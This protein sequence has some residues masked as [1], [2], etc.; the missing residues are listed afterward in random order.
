MKNFEKQFKSWQNKPFIKQLF[1]VFPKAEVFLVGGAVRD[2]ILNR[3]TKDYDLVIRNVSKNQLEKFLSK[4]GKVNLVGK[5]FGVFKFV[6]KGWKG[7]EIDIALPRTEHSIHFSGAYKDFKI[8]S[9]A[10]L[11]IEDDLNR[12]DFTINAMAYQLISEKQQAGKPANSLIDPFNGMKDLKAKKI[13][14]VGDV[15]KR[16]KEDYSRMLRAIRF[17]CQLDFKIEAKTWVEIKKEIKKLIKKIDSGQIIPYEVI[18]KELFKAVGQNPILAI[19][20]LDESG[21]I[22]VLMPE[23]L[24]MK[25]CPQPKNFHSEGDVWKHTILALQ[26]LEDKKFKTEF[27]G[28]KITPEVIWGVIFHDLGKP[29]TIIHADRIRFNNHDTVAARKFKEIA[30]RLKL[31]SAGLDVDVAE[32]IISK[33]MLPVHAKV[34]AMKDTTIEK[35]FFN[36]DFPGQE[37]MMLIFADISATVPPNGKPDFSTYKKL[38][39][40]IN[41]LRKK[42][43]NKKDLPKPLVTGHDLIKKF[44]LESGPKIGE[45]LAILRET[46]LKG[47]IKTKANG[48]KYI[49][50]H[51]IKL[52]NK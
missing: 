36:P 40:R 47:K 46:Q 2:I 4:Q 30:N 1:K 52:K 29:Y 34:A 31:S 7:T 42:S 33:H 21:A 6:P 35:Y 10:K 28:Q 24:K 32:K 11:R 43:R 14:A 20:L 25:K 18:A 38:K 15:K 5:K 44:K 27:K 49:K 17:A 41:K 45:L 12:R 48:L 19:K 9:N 23:L 37:L 22:K 39:A 13:R 3:E 51:V 50:P 8:K 16:F 26:K